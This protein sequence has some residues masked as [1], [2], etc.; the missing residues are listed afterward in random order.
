MTASHQAAEPLLSKDFRNELR[1][2]RAL[3][4]RS[5]PPCEACRRTVDLVSRFPPKGLFMGIRCL[6][7]K[8]VLCARCA[9]GHFASPTELERED[10]YVTGIAEGRR[11]ER[12]QAAGPGAVGEQP[13]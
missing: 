2:L 7:C 11:R 3:R 6:E 13:R 10:S 1:R 8:K 4:E 5:L 9:H 12:A